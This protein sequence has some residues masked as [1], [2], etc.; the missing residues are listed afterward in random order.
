MKRS[1]LLILLGGLLAVS[2]GTNGQLA[3]NPA[4]SDGI[5]YKP[6]PVIKMASESAG[7]PF[8]IERP[9]SSLTIILN[10]PVWLAPYC[11][12]N[13]FWNGPW[14]SWYNPFYPYGWGWTW[15]WEPFDFWRWHDYWCWNRW[16]RWDRPWYGPGYYDP[17]PIIYRS[18]VYYGSRSSAYAQRGSRGGAGYSRRGAISMG[19]GSGRYSGGSFRGSDLSRIT[20]GSVSGGGAVS[21]RSYDGVSRSAVTT[22]SGGYSRSGG[23]T[24]SSSAD[25]RSS[26]L[27][28]SQ[29]SSRSYSGSSSSSRSYSGSSGSSRSYSGS[30]GS[31]R[32]YGGGSSSSRSYGGGPS[33]YRSGGGGHSGGRR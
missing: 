4:F 27:G 17:Y 6:E 15:G 26:S 16:W 13:F 28:G 9:D 25:R 29:S 5:Y 24:R 31:S 30:S 33:S 32:S 7:E 10:G 23:G 11:G 18:N 20:G 14:T 2:C 1:V 8:I 21:G 22:R 3:S 19:A 12:Y